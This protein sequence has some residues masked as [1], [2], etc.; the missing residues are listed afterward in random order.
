MVQGCQ[1]AHV[2]RQAQKEVLDSQEVQAGAP[3]QQHL[4]GM[5]R[6]CAL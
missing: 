5:Q 3:I 1:L 6:A 2:F 4:Q